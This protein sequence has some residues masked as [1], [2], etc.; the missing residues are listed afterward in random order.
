MDHHSSNWYFYVVFLPAFMICLLNYYSTAHSASLNSTHPPAGQIRTKPAPQMGPPNACIPFSR[1]R[2]NLK[3]QDRAAALEALHRALSEVG[4]GSTYVWE[5]P[6]SFLRALITPTS[7]FRDVKG[8]ICR[9]VVYTLSLGHHT[10][11]TEGI[12]C[13][14]PD[15]Q[16]TLTG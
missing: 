12:A 4:D 2:A 6:K 10:R 9:H 8:R 7:S 15:L 11:R 13:R 1:L 16:W 3:A 5:R 14:T